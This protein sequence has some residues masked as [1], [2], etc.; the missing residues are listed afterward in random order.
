M[1]GEK[2]IMKVNA[3]CTAHEDHQYIGPFF[4]PV[5]KILE[6]SIAKEK[7]KEDTGEI[8][9]ENISLSWPRSWVLIRA[10]FKKEGVQSFSVIL[11]QPETEDD[12]FLIE[13]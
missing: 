8:E 13:L 2:V 6:S 11:K 3:D 4:I 12:I 10:D 1:D 5:K 7:F 9:F